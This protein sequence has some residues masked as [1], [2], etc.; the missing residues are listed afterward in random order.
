LSVND[1]NIL[2]KLTYREA[3]YHRSRLS[4]AVI[5]AAAMSAMLVWLIGS[6][7]LVILQFDNNGEKY[8]G[9]YHV[10]VIPVSEGKS[11][12]A[13]SPMR[14]R[15]SSAA[16][17][18]PQKV[19]DELKANDL[20][21][22]VSPAVQIRNT[23]AKY[24]DEDSVLRRLRAGH[25]IPMGSPVIIGIDA[26]ESPFEL[27][28]GKW[29]SPSTISSTLSEDSAESAG[30]AE[31]EGVIGTGA[32]KSLFV[33][34]E[35]ESSVK[36]GDYVAVRIGNKEYK[37]KIVGMVEQKLG[38]AFAPPGASITP[39]VGALFVS[40]KTASILETNILETNILETK[41]ET[42]DEVRR[43]SSVPRPSYLYLRLREGANIKQFKDTWKA[44]LASE[45]FNVSFLDA[46]DIQKSLDNR[47]Q[48]GGPGGVMGS[49]ASLTAVILFTTLISVL[50]VFTALSMGVNERTRVFA[51]MRTI[52]MERK[53]IAV[54]IFGESLILCFLGWIGGILAGWLVLQITVW[55]QPGVFGTG[56]YVS[57]GWS[58]IITSGIAAFIGAFAAAIIPA[59]RGTK[60]QPLEGM[61]RGYIYNVNKMWFYIFGLLGS[62]LLII[63]PFIIYYGV[64]AETGMLRLALY[65]YLGLPTQ[66]LG[67][68]LLI[69]TVV[70]FVEKFFTPLI[71]KLLCIEKNLLKNQLSANLW[72]T[73][74]TTAALSIGL[75]VYSFLEISGY[76]M[77]VP[78][79]YSDKLPNTLAAFLPKGL[80][81]DQ[82]E[83]VKNLDGVDKERFLP[84]ALEQPL[85]PPEEVQ[86][87]LECGMSDMQAKAGIVVFGLDIE[88]AFETT[89]SPG[90]LRRDKR[91]DKERPMIN[92]TLTEGTLK[93]AL[94]KL[95][96]G[97]RY[98]IIPDSF[99]FRA[100]LHIGD[101]VKIVISERALSSAESTR[102]QETLEYEVCGIATVP[103]WLWMAKLSGVRKYGYRSGAMMFAPYE[104]VRND[105]KIDDAAYF[106]F[107]RIGNV[108]DAELENSLQ[109]LADGSLQS[110]TSN[111]SRPMVKVSS[112]NYLNERVGDRADEVIQAAAKIPLILLMISSLAMM[113]TVAASIR[114]RQFELG[115]LRCLG[116][117]RFGLVR[118]ILAEALLIA[119]SAVIISTAFGIIGA[120]CFIGLMR[121]VSFFGGFIS[122]LTIPWY[123]L[124]L[125]FAAT[126]F[127]C[128]L[129]AVFPA[130]AAGRKQPG[131]LVKM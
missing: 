48:R 68:V 89:V 75:G 123:Y 58:A 6:I 69:P 121:Y 10:A 28:E 88:K 63:N 44:H 120:W 56:K 92:L 1:M 32:A 45:G 19:I 103:G 46:D 106:W 70:L 29:F 50:I 9:H 67:L 95:K 47:Q 54:L 16:N 36:A 128:G 99:A 8:L 62:V 31:L 41:L 104:T 130:Y 107:D 118:L 111:Y 81:L 49:A 4:L 3:W 90:H 26:D 73:F 87:L 14:G 96:S 13:D 117:T 61:N 105:F 122:P 59:W 115:V 113:G 20:V 27:E 108:S 84:I 42:E 76:S 51:M 37:I 94:A 24:T 64:N 35:K 82:I 100:R 15:A 72:R 112:R 93:G 98:C 5:A 129:A 53:H 22:Q 11:S 55:L 101:K 18:V 57:L 109:K 83:T 78:Y 102:R 125:G 74:G 131:D 7:G 91:R 86:R 33:W 110:K 127:L 25:G 126:L 2:I 85:F 34:G 80:P 17:F 12:P 30:S 23:M 114:T 124:S 39:A 79:I 38:S 43:S 71:A 40:M 52:G 66:I 60:I 97:E 77:L 116:I 65:S 21:M 119:L